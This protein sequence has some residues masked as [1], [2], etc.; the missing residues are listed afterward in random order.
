M[1]I[2]LLKQADKF[3]FI[4]TRGVNL[5]LFSSHMEIVELGQVSEGFEVLF[6]LRTWI[7]WSL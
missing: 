4:S 3:Y 6:F 5:L 1:V 2:K 7:K